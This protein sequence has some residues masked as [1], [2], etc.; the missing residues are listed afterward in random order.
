MILNQIAWVDCF[1]FL[2]FLAP[3]LLLRVG[4][5]GTAICAVKALPHLGERSPRETMSFNDM[6]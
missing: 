1:A 4:I 3:Q 5:F 2:L 6:R